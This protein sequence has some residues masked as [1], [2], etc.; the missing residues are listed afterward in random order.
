MKKDNNKP[1][2]I[3]DSCLKN[4]ERNKNYIC[5]HPN[6]RTV[7][8]RPIVDRNLLTH[9]DYLNMLATPRGFKWKG[10]TSYYKKLNKDKKNKLKTNQSKR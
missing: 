5:H 2:Y 3:I 8:N 1:M 7:C 10:M 6:Y 9:N 4:V